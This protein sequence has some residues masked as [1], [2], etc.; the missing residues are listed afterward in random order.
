MS[1]QWNWSIINVSGH[2]QFHACVIIDIDARELYDWHQQSTWFYICRNRRYT[3]GTLDWYPIA[4]RYAPPVV[5]HE[6]SEKADQTLALSNVRCTSLLI[7]SN[8]PH[9]CRLNSLV[10]HQDQSR[11][12]LGRQCFY[13]RLLGYILCPQLSTVVSQGNGGPSHLVPTPCWEGSTRPVKEIQVAE[14]HLR[15]QIISSQGTWMDRPWIRLFYSRMA[16][17]R[18]V[19]VQR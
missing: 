12:N 16:P 8:P 2:G 5:L 3:D 17:I 4:R 1:S 19:D 14:V 15:R 6:A 7:P 10:D 13:N 11:R 18:L 9:F